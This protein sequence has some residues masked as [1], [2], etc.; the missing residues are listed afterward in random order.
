MSI[1]EL[2]PLTKQRIPT[3]VGYN[4]STNTYTIGDEARLTGLNG[5]TTVFNFKPA[6]GGGDS[7]F[8]SKNPYWF[9]YP[10]DESARPSGKAYV[11]T[12]T[13]KQAAHRF[14]K[15]LF[16]NV[17]MPEKIIV[18]EPAIRDET[19]KENFRR[20][21]REVF[22]ELNLVQLEFFP[23]P[24]AVFQYY[25]HVAKVFPVANQAEVVLIIDIGGGTF[26]S[27]IIRT[28][29]QGMLARGGATS[30]PLG[31]QAEMCGGSHIDKALLT[32]IIDKTKKNGLIWKD[33]PFA[34]IEQKKTPALLRIEDAKIKLSEAMTRIKRRRLAD[35]FSDITTSV[36]LPRGECHPDSD[37]EET[38]T[39]EDLKIVIQDMWRRHYGE[40]IVKTVNEAKERL[41]AMKSSLTR[42]DK[43]L[44]AGGSSRLPFMKE[45]IST[46]LPTLVS[47]ENIF[48]G[49]DIGEAV[50]YGI[51]CECREQIKRDPTLS[52]G[53][54]APC[55]LNDLYLGFKKARNDSVSIPRIRHKNTS[56]K[57]GQLLSTPFEIEGSVLK[58]EVDLP[59]AVNNKL[60]YLFTDKP[61]RN[62]INVE[63]INLGNDVISIPKLNKLSKKCEL[64]L[65]IKSN[66]FIK[67]V[68]YFY[69]KGSAADKNGQAVECPEF[70]FPNFQVKEGNAYIGLDFGTS[71]SYLVRFASIPE[72]V[73][74]TQYP[75]FTVSPKVKSRLMDLNLRI[76]EYREGG[77]FSKERL[78]QHAQE[79]ALEI[80]FHSNKIEGNSLSKG[81]TQL[82]LSDPKRD[83]LSKSQLE[84]KNLE[85][86]Y[87][88]ML[89]R[90]DSCFDQPESFIRELNRLVVEDVEAGDGQYRS[91]PVSLSG[92]DFV[93]PQGTSVPI[94]MQQLGDEIK[95]A[96]VDRSPLEFA[97]SLHT[98]LVC[99]HPFVDGNGRTA[100]LLL[101]AC[102]LNQGLPVIVV[103][104]ADRGR[105][106]DCLGESNTGNLSPLI[107][108]VIECFEQQLNDFTIP[109]NSA[110]TPT[111]MLPAATQTLPEP[112][113]GVITQEMGVAGN[114]DDAISRAIQEVSTLPLDDSLAAVMKKKVHELAQVR[115][116][117]Y[118]AWQQ[119][120]L[121]VLAELKAVVEA[122]NA[123][124]KQ[125]GFQIYVKE[126][127]LLTF[128]KYDDICNGRGAT[129]TWF[130]G[131]ELISPR[132]RER[133]L[134]FFNRGDWKITQDPK[135][136]KVSLVVSRF[137]GARYQRL[138]A[139]PIGL[140]EIG[141]RDGELIFLYPDAISKAASVREVLTKFLS[142]VIESY[143]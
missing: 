30:V 54:I 66:G 18:G 118:R 8:S 91:E 55:I 64:H 5:K 138:K 86:A 46:V 16:E 70:Y 101:N 41:L 39:G 2:I 140:R 40:I 121:T 57:D 12:F 69:G 31:L 98:K 84:A 9:H 61:I 83:G 80:I 25:R 137:Y 56:L 85:T 67:P 135:A 4:L 52:A 29:E 112:E 20:H 59:F 17:E 94:F 32:K 75:E 26:N 126:Y 77:C 102:L 95:T 117:E 72:E 125:Q 87:Y 139:E 123:E 50:A 38:L 44:V 74:A 21:M 63:H 27:C 105:Y 81:E 128:E 22:S 127:D 36:L 60:F 58:F 93:P 1:E 48:I 115:V 37:I 28:T 42:I 97:T 110:D 103:N 14:L 82:V 89:E 65:D 10:L 6:F 134:L 88:W 111:D 71:N 49:S 124:Y 119:S 100:R 19:W 96:G 116:A 47:K 34:R 136:S 33:N 120:F 35:D 104:Y 90:A 99:I 143:L 108:F 45:E 3:I 122:F 92:M 132:C 11:E 141:Y 78:I 23:E 62:A 114:T 76:E 13:A 129:R 113:T 73:T 24:F 7:A 107:D 15:T 79:Q 106:L 53:K 43:V 130:L 142:E 133:L 51:A 109:I 68:F 131:L